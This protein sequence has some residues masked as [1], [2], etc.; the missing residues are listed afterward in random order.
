MAHHAGNIIDYS[1]VEIDKHHL[2]RCVLVQ[3]QIIAERVVS[4]CHLV[5]LYGEEEGVYILRSALVLNVSKNAAKLTVAVVVAIEKLSELMD[6]FL[7]HGV[8][9]AVWHITKRVAKQHV[10]GKSE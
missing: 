2:A 6:I 5:V 9:V 4:A 7:C 10:G 8:A 1:A 3:T